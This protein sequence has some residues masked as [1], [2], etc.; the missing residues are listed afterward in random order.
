MNTKKLTEASIMSALFIVCTI[1][2]ITTGLFYSL[3]IDSVIPIFIAIIYLRCDTKYTILAMITCLA[4]VGL[5]MGKIGS[6]I[7][8]SQSMMIGFMCGY[9]IPKK[10]KILDDILCL[11][12]FS[13]FIM[14]LIDIYCSKLIGFSFIKDTRDMM[15]PLNLNKYYSDIIFYIMI[16]VLPLGTTIMTYLGSL[17]IGDRIKSLKGSG[18]DKIY[19]I[20]NIRHF[21]SYIYCSMKLVYICL[22]YLLI[23]QIKNV[24]NINIS[25]PYILTITESIKY[26]MYYFIIRD[27]YAY[28]RIYT[29]KKT[30]SILI[31]NL[32]GIGFIGTLILDFNIGFWVIAI[33]SFIYIP[34][35]LIKT[36]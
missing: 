21:G 4:I 22:V 5:V 31:L 12:I 2:A 14:V 6:A 13:C 11:S 30:K 36:S 28:M 16:A 10:S 27:A 20:K 19:I 23:M 33:L 9:M 17:F 25:Q 35:K 1:F 18:K 15:K 8:M 32:L 24:L 26:I 34:K 7:W 3:Y 29:Y